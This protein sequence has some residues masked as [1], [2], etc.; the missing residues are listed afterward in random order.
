MSENV[1]E[2][3]NI[4]GISTHKYLKEEKRIQAF[5]IARTFA[6]LCVILCHS[7]EGA[8][9]NINYLYLSNIS[10]IVRI[11]LFTIGRLGVPIFL[12]LTG[13]LTLKKQIETDEDVLKFYKRNLLSLFI[14]IEIWNVLYNIFN[15]F[16]DGVF[17]FKVLMKNIL[18]LEQVNVSSMWYMPMILGMYISIPFI[19]KIVKSFSINSLKYPIII[20]FLSSILLPSINT[21]FSIL[22][23][24]QFN[25]IISLSFLGGGYGLYIILGYYLNSGLLNKISN[26]GIVVISSILFVAICFIQYWAYSKNIS[27]NVWYNSVFLFIS[28][29]G[30][31]E[32]FRRIKNKENENLFIKL[33]KYISKISLGLFFLHKIILNP[34]IRYFRKFNFNNPIEICIFFFLTTILSIIFI[35]ITSKIKIIKEKIFFVKG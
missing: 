34:L 31:F 33:S 17:N 13:A 29:I 2:H 8:Y 25:L 35:Y 15:Y 1:L 19:A 27:Y 14:T 26:I 32:M 11:I 23:L 20:V 18:F 22:G 10:Q 5:D 9:S 30:I 7:V 3:A 12:L 4:V 28:S 24:G 21:I 16:M 6:I